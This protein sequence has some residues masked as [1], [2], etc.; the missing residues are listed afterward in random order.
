MLEDDETG[1]LV[2]R[3]GEV[4]DGQYQKYTAMPGAYIR[5][6]FFGKYPELLELVELFGRQART[7]MRRGGHDPEKVFAAYQKMTELN[8]GPAHRDPGQ[9]DQ[10]LRTGRSRRRPQH[11]AQQEEANEEELREFRSRFGIPISDEDV[12]K[13]PFYKPP[14]TASK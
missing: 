6:H 4:V 3:M 5:E 2:K 8:E 9:D 7:S 1:L 11:H 14:E 12:A 13:A 10:R